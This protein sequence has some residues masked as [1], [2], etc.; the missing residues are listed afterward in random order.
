MEFLRKL[1]RR[2]PD[3][4]APP[5]SQREF[6][7]AVLQRVQEAFSLAADAGEQGRSAE[8]LEQAE[9]GTALLEE[10]DDPAGRIAI[11]KQYFAPI[12]ARVARD[13]SSKQDMELA[14]R[15]WTAVSEI[16]RAAGDVP[17][18]ASSLSDKA[19]TLFVAARFDEALNIYS[20]EVLPLRE[21]QGEQS[22]LAETHL[23][24]A[25]THWQLGRAHDAYGALL[26]S[27]RLFAAAGD[28]AA[29]KRVLLTAVTFVDKGHPPTNE[30]REKV[31]ALA[32]AIGEWE[33]ERRFQ[34][35][36][37][38][39][40]TS[41]ES[42]SPSSAAFNFRPVSVFISYTRGDNDA[43]VALFDH[44]NSPLFD[45]FI[46]RARLEPGY[47]WEPALGA[48]L[49]RADVLVVLVGPRTL[50]RPYVL[51]EIAMF[52]AD[53]ANRPRP[54]IPI[55]MKGAP[56]LPQ[57]LARFQAFDI[58]AGRMHDLVTPLMQAI[59]NAVYSGNIGIDPRQR[60]PSTSADPES[61]A[62]IRAKA[63]AGE[64]GL[65]PKILVQMTNAGIIAP[66]QQCAR[67]EF[68][69]RLP[70]G[71]QCPEPAI[72]LCAS[73]GRGTCSD[74]AH[75]AGRFTTILGTEENPWVV[76]QR[77]FYWCASCQAPSCTLCLKLIDGYP[78]P[79]DQVLDHRFFCPACHEILQVVTHAGDDMRAAAVAVGRWAH[80]LGPPGFTK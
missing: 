74:P 37:T 33:I 31:R 39:S 59:F 20:N 29:V 27:G 70:S 58:R 41:G 76:Q 36:A 19:A 40:G 75:I 12:L 1:F 53:Q 8:A 21:R 68:D 11:R 67:R 23:S 15:A 78:V 30:Q 48:Q 61:A 5:L 46:D 50:D 34:P 66:T 69:P 52:L 57:T 71:R 7:D 26:I 3:T 25:L 60:G 14:V 16:E 42:T 63:E 73:C 22:K 18:L 79:L 38:P 10:L 77:L 32:E 2:A 44:L 80:A 13:L 72:V 51:K 6:R 65:P 43:A 35:P 56:E 9:Q 17:A 45:V 54:V 64:I 4:A 49:T 24:I 47:E 62:M 28:T 55:L